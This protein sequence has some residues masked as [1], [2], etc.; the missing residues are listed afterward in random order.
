MAKKATP[1]IKAAATIMFDLM[2][3]A[4]SGWRAI[5]SIAEVPI[6]PIPIAAANAANAAPKPAAACDIAML[7]IA[8]KIVLSVNIVLIFK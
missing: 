3:P 4:A 6:F 7:S 1:S 2:S 8:N 5:D